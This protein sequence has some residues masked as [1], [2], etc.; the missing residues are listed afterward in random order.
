M[1]NIYGQ[2]INR[3]ETELKINVTSGKTVCMGFFITANEIWEE[4]FRN[5]IKSKHS[6]FSFFQ[7]M[8]K[9]I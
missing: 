5:E 6:A 2:R 1:R 4:M 7:G 9:K 3:N 8:S